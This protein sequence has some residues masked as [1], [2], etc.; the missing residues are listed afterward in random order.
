MVTC[1]LGSEGFG[2]CLWEE[3]DNCEETRSRKPRTSKKQSLTGDVLGVQGT[4]ISVKMKTLKVKVMRF[5]K[6]MRN[7][8]DTD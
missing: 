8:L 6:G 1:P 7:N 3:L 4:G 2:T 5:K